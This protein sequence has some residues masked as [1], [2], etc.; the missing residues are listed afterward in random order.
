MGHQQQTIYISS[1][2]PM[3]TSEG[4]KKRRPAQPSKSKE[5]NLQSTSSSHTQKSKDG[6]LKGQIVPGTC[7]LVYPMSANTKSIELF[8]KQKNV[9]MVE[10]SKRMPQQEVVLS[11]TISICI[12]R[13]DQLS[14]PYL[15]MLC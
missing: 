11:E 10:K 2:R 8:A 12:H 6:L 15:S 7:L 9:K 14:H 1:A 4:D 3:Y 13:E 5:Q